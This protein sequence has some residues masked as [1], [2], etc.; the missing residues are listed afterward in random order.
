VP[1]AV[2][3]HVAITSAAHG[4]SVHVLSAREPNRIARAGH[5]CLAR[6]KP[7]LQGDPTAALERDRCT[8]YF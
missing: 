7:T 4:A 6:S 1:V 3:R 8:T 5:R 2:A